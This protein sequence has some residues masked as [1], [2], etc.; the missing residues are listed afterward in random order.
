[1][2]KQRVI[3]A[4]ARA[5][6]EVNRAYCLGCGCRCLSVGRA[7]DCACGEAPSFL[8]AGRMDATRRP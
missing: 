2:D 7:V 4:C 8:N 3:E 6:H 1:M 5:A